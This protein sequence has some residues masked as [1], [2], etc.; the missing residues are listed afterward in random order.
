MIFANHGLRAAVKAI[1]KTLTTLAE[2]GDLRTVAEDIVPMTEIFELQGTTRMK[3]R[4]KKYVR[5]GNADITTVILAAGI[6]QDLYLENLLR[7]EIP[8][9]MLD[10][11]GKTILE[12]NLA[13]LEKIGIKDINV[14]TGFQA[15]K[16]TYEKVN[17]FYNPDFESKRI[18][19][20]I[21]QTEKIL[22]NRTLLCYGDIVFDQIL[23]ERLAKSTGDITLVV[24]A[25]YK[26]S[27]IRNR[28]LDL[29]VTTDEPILGIRK[30]DQRTRNPVLKI[31][32]KVCDDESTFE[33]IGIAFF[34]E[35]GIQAFKDTY[36]KAK[37]KYQNSDFNGAANID[38]ADFCD[39]LQEMI[40]DGHTVDILEVNSGWS[41]V[42]N[43]E[44]Y[45]RISKMLTF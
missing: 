2:T 7:H 12:R 33:F 21:F 42:H 32:R 10:I 13:T 15:E 37:I 29:L 39:L 31:G 8:L 5:S 43:F 3:E 23:I 1:K 25:S 18:L 11:N 4:E 34:S 6:P 20:S 38:Q 44:D 17:K 45:K 30:I 40:N 28:K 16:I 24:D 22:N 26:T 9:V 36:Q 41:E 14:V 19:H 27:N 35:K